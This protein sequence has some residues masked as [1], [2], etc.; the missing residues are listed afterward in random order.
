MKWKAARI[1]GQYKKKDRIFYQKILTKK[2]V[3]I[4]TKKRLCKIKGWN[5]FLKFEGNGNFWS[6][7]PYDK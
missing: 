3:F 7:R 5:K 4:V 1:E 6:Q 2:R